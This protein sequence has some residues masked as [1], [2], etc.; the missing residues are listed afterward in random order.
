MTEHEAERLRALF[1][2][3]RQPDEQAAPDFDL[4]WSAAQSALQKTA[5]RPRKQFSS[6]FALVT[7][8]VAVLILAA[9]L[10]VAPPGKHEHQATSLTEFEQWRSPTVSLLN[11]A[12]PQTLSRWEQ[13]PTDVLLD[14]PGQQFL[15]TT[16]TVGK[17]KWIL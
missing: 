6:R 16:P 9:L 13:T 7:A 14:L 3:L 12:L 10:I 1:A 11:A 15:H 5:V 4:M 2:Q 17:P 8:G